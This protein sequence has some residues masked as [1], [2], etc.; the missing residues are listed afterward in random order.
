MTRVTYQLINI[1]HNRAWIELE[2]R[3]EEGSIENN[4]CLCGSLD[5]RRLP[6]IGQFSKFYPISFMFI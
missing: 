3:K 5:S 1:F 6:K 4:N 2:T